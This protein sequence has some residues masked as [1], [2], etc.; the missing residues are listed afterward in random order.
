MS[1]KTN[2]SDTDA[3]LSMML[4]RRNLTKGAIKNYNTV[5]REIHELFEVTPSEI[6]RIGK[7]EQK[8]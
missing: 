1:T 6:V 3:K 7:R 5:F 2:F 4:E 8:P